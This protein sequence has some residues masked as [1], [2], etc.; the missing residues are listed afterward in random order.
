MTLGRNNKLSQNVHGEEC[1]WNVRMSH[2]HT[3]THTQNHII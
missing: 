1:Y 3:H 2:T